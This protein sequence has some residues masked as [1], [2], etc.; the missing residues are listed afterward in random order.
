MTEVMRELPVALGSRMVLAVV[1]LVIQDREACVFEVDQGVHGRRAYACVCHPKLSLEEWN[2]F[3]LVVSDE[4]PGAVDAIVSR[5]V[6]KDISRLQNRVCFT[7]THDGLTIEI[8]PHHHHA[9]ESLQV[10][11]L[12]CLNARKQMESGVTT[13][14]RIT[15]ALRRQCIE[16]GRTVLDP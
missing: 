7:V 8:T 12:R 3:H 15:E 5:Q 14:D 16:T 10:T 4:F 1:Q 13:I 9:D 6:A 11:D 2:D